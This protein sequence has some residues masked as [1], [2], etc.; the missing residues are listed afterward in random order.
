MKQR[1]TAKV[2]YHFGRTR[3]GGCFVDNFPVEPHIHKAAFTGSLNPIRT[4]YA[5]QVAQVSRL[6]T[7]PKR[8]IGKIQAPLIT[9]VINLV[10]PWS[11]QAGRDTKIHWSFPG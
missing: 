2:E 11:P 4:T 8:W 3:K 7:K 6:D 5:F 9:A 1:L 10:P